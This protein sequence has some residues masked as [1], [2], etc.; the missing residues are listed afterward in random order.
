MLECSSE[1]AFLVNAEVDS[2]KGVIDGGVGTGVNT[3]PCRA[4]IEKAQE[5]IRLEIDCREER[6]RELEF[7]EKGG[8]PLDFKFSHAVSVSVQ[9]TSLTDQHPEQIVTS[10][11]KDCYVSTALRLRHG[12]AVESFGKPG[13]TT[14]EA[15]SGDNLLLFDGENKLLKD[16][17]SKSRGSKNIAS[18]SEFSTRTGGIHKAKGAENSVIFRPYARRNRSKFNRD[19]SRSVS[20]DVAHARNNQASAHPRPGTRDA[21]GSLSE[22]NSKDQKLSSIYKLKSSNRIG[23]V[24]QKNVSVG[25]A[26]SIGMPTADRLTHS[27]LGGRKERTTDAKTNGDLLGSRKNHEKTWDATSCNA[28]IEAEER[29]ALLSDATTTTRQNGIACQL[30]GL[31]ESKKMNCTHIGEDSSY[32]DTTTVVLAVEPPKNDSDKCADRMHESSNENPRELASVV[33]ETSKPLTEDLQGIEINPKP[34]DPGST[35]IGDHDTDHDNINSLVIKIEEDQDLEN[36]SITPESLVIIKPKESEVLEA[37]KNEQNMIDHIFDSQNDETVGVQT[38]PKALHDVGSDAIPSGMDSTNKDITDPLACNKTVK[39]DEDSVLAE[40][41]LIQAKRKRIAELPIRSLPLENHQKSHWDFLLEEMAWLANDFI[42]ERLWKIAAAAQISRRAALSSHV[43]DQTQMPV[44]RMKFVAHAMAKAVMDFWHS[45]ELLVNGKSSCRI[46]AT[47]NAETEAF[48][49]HVGGPPL[50]ESQSPSKNI[51]LKSYALRF[52]R[53]NNSTVPSV[54]AGER[55]TSNDMHDSGMGETSGETCIT[56]DDLF[57]AIPHGAMECYRR[58]IESYVSQCEKNGSMQKTDDTTMHDANEGEEMSQDNVYYEDEGETSTQYLPG[59]VEW[60]Q[61]SKFPYKKQ[62][63][64]K[65]TYTSGSYELGAG[66]AYRSHTSGTLN[67]VLMIK[68]PASRNVVSIPIKRMRTAPRQRVLGSSSGVGAV[69]ML[70]LN[71]TDV[72][73]GDTSSY[74]DDQS[75]LHGAS[76]IQRS[77]EVESPVEFEKYLPID[78]GEIST[79]HKKKKKEKNMNSS[80]EHR[81]LHE[82]AILDDIG[83]HSKRRLD[84]HHLDSNGNN[85]LFGHHRNKKFRLSKQTL[86]NVLDNGAPTMGSMPSPVASQMSNMSNANEYKKMIVNRDRL[87]KAKATKLPIPLSGS[88]SAWTSFEDQALVVLVHDLGP[89]WELVSD[90]INSTLYFKRIF[91]GPKECKERH[92]VL[93]DQTAGDG[94]D[95]ADDSGSSQPYPS[96]MPGI[97]KGSARQLFQRLHAPMEED[98]VKSHFEKIIMIGQ[99]QHHCRKQCDS[100]DQ[101]HVTPPHNSHMIAMSQISPNNQNGGCLTPLDLID[102]IMSSPDAL[103]LGYQSPQT[104]GFANQSC[105][106]AVLPPHGANPIY[107]G[108]VSNSLS[109]PSGPLSHRNGRCNI[110]RTSLPIDDQ[111]RIQQLNPT[112]SSRNIQQSTITVPGPH[113]LADR[114]GARKLQGGNGMGMVNGINSRGMPVSRPGFQGLASSAILDSAAALSPGMAGMPSLEMQST[115]G[116]TQG[117]S[118]QRPLDN[119]HQPGQSMEHHRQMTVPEVQMRATQANSHCVTHINGLSANYTSQAGPSAA[120]SYSVHPQQK[121][122]MS[123]QQTHDITSPQL[124]HLR[125]PNHAIGSQHPAYAL[126]VKEK[127]LQQQHQQ[128]QMLQQKQQYSVSSAM[129]SQTLPHLPVSVQNSPQVQP[130]SSQGISHSSVSPSSPMTPMHS[131]LQQKHHLPPHGLIRDSQ[132]GVS[133][134]PSQVTKQRQRHPQQQQQAVR[135]HTAH[136]QQR[137]HLQSHQ[138]GKQLKGEGKGNIVIPPNATMDQSNLNGQSVSSV[139]QSTDKVVQAVP[140]DGSKNSIQPSRSLGFQTS[141]QSQ[142]QNKLYPSVSNSPNQMQQVP[143]LLENGNQG[144]V[145]SPSYV[146]KSST[147]HQA[148]SPHMVSSPSHPHIQLQSN[149]HH[150]HVGQTQV[151]LRRPENSDYVSQL[152]EHSVSIDAPSV[153]NA[154]TTPQACMESMDE[155]NSLVTQWQPPEV[156][157][158]SPM[159]HLSSQLG[160][161][162]SPPAKSTGSDSNLAVGSGS[163]RKQS[164]GGLTSSAKSVG[165]R[166]QQKSQIQYPV[167]PSTSQQQE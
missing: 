28:G 46:I 92:K 41:K 154:A 33:G 138:H 48:E 111:Q 51:A 5:E 106:P 9:S 145:T 114:F 163:I 158:E 27:L 78:S 88:G 86:E 66:L 104:N 109:S 152:D 102:A 137:Q 132:S 155:R 117:N 10:K 21:K 140:V 25:N 39:M 93:M 129:M 24:V 14:C 94:A 161:S 159:H 139:G 151:V 153:S 38:F 26:E 115:I 54:E 53:Y 164:S 32:L 97:P 63:G 156:L 16:K 148:T 68:R 124:P 49:D 69:N 128:H 101:K 127:Q 100:H 36:K 19:G 31:E 79:K 7:L 136:A 2:M 3:S 150:K 70:A 72:S 144:L 64:L 15:N 55:L 75:H 74:Q 43:R 167:G 112:F 12:E 165:E 23:D 125:G 77:L 57:Y 133:H 40:A 34:V 85:G 99:K 8:D 121:H 166:W 45:N 35:V 37:H 91:R 59:T 113:V 42:Q 67:S 126:L 84:G 90:A 116:S 95:S 17:N 58:S 82:S 141:S 52:L 20:M 160:S 89:N 80:Y 44:R 107:Q 81:W 157:Q 162:G 62:K 122:Q 76:Q 119:S 22:A 143:P 149:S 110:S 61:A 71:K 47:A 56:E 135:P 146:S 30:D 73:S 83:D 103:G 131:Q 105:V 142:L 108:S 130:Q 98:T 50:L 87:R 123:L 29:T 1:S 65:R 18:P 120:Q 6:L 134:L 11:A 4:E 60:S 118:T 96:T 13:D 147:S